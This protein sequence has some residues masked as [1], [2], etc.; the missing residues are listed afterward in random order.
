VTGVAFLGAFVGVAS[1]GGGSPV[2]VYTFIA[3]VVLLW[4]W[5]S[6]LAVH[7]YRSA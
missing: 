7:L 1:S 2:I 6:A 4:T 5:M 3:A